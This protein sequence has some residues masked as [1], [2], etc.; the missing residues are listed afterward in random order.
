MWLGLLLLCCFLIGSSAAVLAEEDQS[1]TSASKVKQTALYV[2]EQKKLFSPKKAKKY[3]VKVKNKKIVSFSEGVMKGLKAGKTKVWLTHTKTGKKTCYD[4][5]VYK[6][7]RE[8]TASVRKSEYWAG[9]TFSVKVKTVPKTNVEPVYYKVSNPKVAKVTEDGTVTVTGVGSCKI[10]AYTEGKKSVK[11]SVRIWGVKDPEIGF[12]IGRTLEMEL[13]EVVPFSIGCGEYPLKNITVTSSDTNVIRVEKGSSVRAVRLGTAK[14]VAV[15]RNGSKAEVK[16]T[17]ASKKG[18]LTAATLRNYGAAGCKKLMIVA[19]PDD[20]T[21]WGGGHMMSGDWFIVCL[22]NG[23]TM[24][25]ANEYRSVLKF[26]GNKG[27]ILNYLDSE[28]GK[29]SEW[30]RDRMGIM[31]DLK[32]LLRFKNWEQIVTYNPN[33]VTGHI[34]HIQTYNLVKQACKM[35][36]T[37]HKLYYFGAYYAAGRVPAGLPRMSEEQ[38][39]FKEKTLELYAREMDAI[40]KYWRQMVPHENWELASEWGNPTKYY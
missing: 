9:D 17:V 18:M 30:E 27:V 7:I 6:K 37:Y 31:N 21:L 25:R 40:N 23:Q 2:G 33:G 19:H 38:I 36:G 4:V 35:V 20:E 3:T 16:V 8:L 26:T 11:S 32:L 14:L 10:T 29:R 28:E 22:T 15:T 13:G 1:M 5:T 24:H 39:A 34:H 12:D